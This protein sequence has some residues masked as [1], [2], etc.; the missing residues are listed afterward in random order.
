VV[1]IPLLVIFFLRV[2]RH[3]RCIAA[4]IG[5]IEPLEPPAVPPASPSPSWWFSARPFGSF[6]S[7]S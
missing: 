5:T 4:Q 3:Y 1:L 2:N 7:R 6:W